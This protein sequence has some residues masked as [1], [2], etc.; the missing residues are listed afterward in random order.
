MPFSPECPVHA[1]YKRIR[2]EF[3][4]KLK[5]RRRNFVKGKMEAAGNDQKKL[6][7]ALAEITGYKELDR[8]DTTEISAQS[9]AD[10]L[11]AHM[12]SPRPPMESAHPASETTTG[13][14]FE[15]QQVSVEVVK[16]ALRTLIPTGNRNRSHCPTS[17]AARSICGSYSTVKHYQY[18]HPTI[19]LPAAVG[20][21]SRA[22]CILEQG[23][24]E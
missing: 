8:E 10:M 11:K 19:A 15:N 7:K 14:S 16:I 20:K 6:W 1:E 21:G 17:L 13:P 18:I 12:S 5:T 2:E 4:K 22:P 23:Q 3:S 24:Q 9:L